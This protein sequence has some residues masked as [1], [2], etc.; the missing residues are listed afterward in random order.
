MLPEGLALL[1]GERQ[2]QPV[3]TGGGK[4]VDWR[5]ISS[6]LGV[7]TFEVKSESSSSKKGKVEITIPDIAG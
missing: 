6:K 2:T 1:D 4:R 7:Q 3:P 5:V